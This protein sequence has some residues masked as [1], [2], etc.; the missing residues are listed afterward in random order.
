MTTN[1]MG[2]RARATISNHAILT[3]R[4]HSMTAPLH[5]V[6]GVL[7]LEMG[8]LERVVVDLSRLFCSRGH[9]VSVVCLERRGMLASEAEA[10]GAAVYCL[11]N[12][13]GRKPRILNR[14]AEL[15]TVLRPDVLHTHNFKCLWHLGP[16][17]RTISGPPVLH[18]AHTDQIARQRSLFRKLRF[19]LLYR[20]AAR[21][22]ERFCGVTD[23]VVASAGRWGSIPRSK[24]KTV[25]N[26]VN[27]V[28]FG[29]RSPRD[30][31]REQF[32][33]PS[34]ARVVGSV[35]RLDEVKQQDL[36][37]AGVAKLSAEY[38]DVRVLLVGDGPMRRDL[39]DLAKSLG[40]AE[41]VHFAGFQS[42]PEHY[43]AAMD[44]FALTS[45]IEG[46]PLALLEAWASGL[47]VVCSAVGGIPKLLKHGETGLLFARGD[48]GGFTE[49][50]R[51]MFSNASSATTMADAGQTLVR[52]KYSLERMANEYEHHYR[53][54]IAERQGAR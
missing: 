39:E 23:E 45:R 2:T 20:L 14:A 6:H 28:Q 12:P 32:A 33:I 43:Y 41:R 21:F 40:L 1:H 54:L 48:T 50:L 37:L 9:R 51:S 24:L 3:R 17:A 35:G 52:E 47:P 42:A 22:A 4:P 15:L 27:A 34:S 8:G 30:Q 5:I 16:T 18:T 49:A 38:D 13:P 11:D 44:V 36:L 19:R 10:S 46:L 26:G 25:L 7:S 29:D 31:I 53:A